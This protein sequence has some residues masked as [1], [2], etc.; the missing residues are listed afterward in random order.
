MTRRPA[1]K[2]RETWRVTSEGTSLRRGDE[3]S[4][5]GQGHDDHED[6]PTA[7]D[8]AATGEEEN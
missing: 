3:K 2:V 8:S 5:I 6:S 1:P 4:E 7:G